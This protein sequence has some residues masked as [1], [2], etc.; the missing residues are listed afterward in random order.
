[1]GMPHLQ[2][3]TKD[4]KRVI[5]MTAYYQKHFTGTSYAQ[6]AVGTPLAMAYAKT[7]IN[8]AAP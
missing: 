4:H 8:K 2:C 7:K 3:E 6:V 5:I 1:M